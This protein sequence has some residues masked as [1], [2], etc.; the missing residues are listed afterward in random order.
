[1]FQPATI[2]L[3]LKRFLKFLLNSPS[4][5]MLT[6]VE[7]HCNIIETS[8]SSHNINQHLHS[9]EELLYIISYSPGNGIETPRKVMYSSVVKEKIQNIEIKLLYQDGNDFDIG[10]FTVYLHLIH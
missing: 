3:N 4:E 1:M 2:L 6:P 5:I 10:D 9:E 7:V 8:L